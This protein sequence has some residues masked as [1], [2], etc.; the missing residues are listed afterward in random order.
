MVP[1]S[2]PGGRT[3]ALCLCITVELQGAERKGRCYVHVIGSSVELD[4]VVPALHRCLVG[5]EIVHGLSAHSENRARTGAGRWQGGHCPLHSSL[6]FSVMIY[7]MVASEL[8]GKPA[9]AQLVEH[10]TV[11]TLQ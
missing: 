5:Q 7:S 1:G 4:F 9:I 11:D 3:C 2:I 6:A 8:H 10:L